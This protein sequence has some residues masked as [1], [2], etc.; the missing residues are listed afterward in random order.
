[1]TVYSEF[2]QLL[3]ECP[4]SEEIPTSHTVLSH[5]VAA[6]QHGDVTYVE[7]TFHHA[8]QASIALA[9]HWA[10]ENQ[11]LACLT[12]LAK[13]SG[14]EQNT[15]AMIAAASE[16]H[17]DVV[18][19]LLPFSEPKTAN[20]LAL[21]LAL[22]GNHW[23]CAAMLKDVSDCS[24]GCGFA[25]T[26][27]V[28]KN[29]V[30]AFEY[31]LP[32]ARRDGHF[33]KTYHNWLYN[34]KYLLAR[35]KQNSWALILA[36]REGHMHFIQPLLSLSNPKA[37]DS[38]ALI[39]AAGKGHTDLVK[40]LLPYSDPTSC[41]SSALI[42]AALNGHIECVKLLLPYS[43]PTAR[44][45]AALLG[46]VGNGHIE[47]VK[48]LLPYSDPTANNGAILACAVW[49]C[50]MD[51]VQLL[52]PVSKLEHHGRAL[53]NA[54]WGLCW[55]EKYALN[56]LG[57]HTAMVDLFCTQENCSKALTW[58]KRPQTSNDHNDPEIQEVVCDA[59]EQ[60][61]M[62]YQQRQLLLDSIESEKQIVQRKL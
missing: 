27:A 19:V 36:A 48:L 56:S 41:D 31:L 58:L 7:Q 55:S 20:S 17:A 18:E 16:G 14:V 57:A 23:N 34:C 51:L 1:M 37:C 35:G 11:H 40:L 50:R 22:C 30:K 2:L 38:A 6:A 60:R 33:V 10:A 44:D 45:S 53:V 9:L 5:L 52:L 46:A 62:Q 43:D 8:D 42:E 24:P 61:L 3:K 49:K 12:I 4:I 25:L 59:I 28:K 39:E 21:R 47:C 13:V 15:W 29:D 26:E 32:F 54:Y